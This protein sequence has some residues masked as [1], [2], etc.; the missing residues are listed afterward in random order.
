MAIVLPKREPKRTFFFSPLLTSLSSQFRR[1]AAPEGS[2]YT[3]NKI[4]ACDNEISYSKTKTHSA[5]V[6]IQ[7]PHLLFAEL[8]C[9][10][11]AL[12]TGIP[13]VAVVRFPTI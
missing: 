1:K 12:C 3:G 9:T 11:D 2:I 8:E 10:P 13:L 6:S 4:F 7:Q 5:E